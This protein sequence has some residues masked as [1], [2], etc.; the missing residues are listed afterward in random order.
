MTAL[1][2]RPP[3]GVVPWPLILLEGPEKSGKS[4]AAAEFTACDRIGQTYWL[5]IGEGAADE[6][7]AIPGANYLVVEHDGSWADIIGQVEAVRDEAAK[8]TDK[9]VVLVIDSM[10]A[11]WNLLKDWT[12]QR[13]R[14]SKAGKKALAADPDAEVKPGM[15]LWNDANGRHQHL[16]HLLMTF[17][18]IVIVTARGKEVASLDDNGRPI[19]G[20]KEHKVDAHKDLA[21][22]VTA[23][24]SLNRDTS[25]MV[26]GVR[27]VHSGL[28]P[29]VD[30]PKLAPQFSL[31]WLIFDV[32]KCDP[33][34]AHVRDHVET[35]PSDRVQIPESFEAK[36]RAGLT[37]EECHKAHAYLDKVNADP[38]KVAELRAVVQRNLEE[39]AREN[40]MAAID[41]D[42]DAAQTTLA[43]ELG[44]QEKAS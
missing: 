39:S 31:E 6:Y 28:R 24:V 5:D 20:S 15:N 2:V 17:P 7:A 1:R 14:Q 9:P 23:W 32:L 12:S 35:D 34:T 16:M 13:A 40:V 8:T 30:K 44:A 42:H 38:E 29:G 3:T 10:T 36:V 27:S 33:A 43:D 21:F 41:P 4:F 11:E 18:G 22:D 19:P 26:R 37:V 25:P